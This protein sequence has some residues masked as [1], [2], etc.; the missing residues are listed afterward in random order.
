MQQ[1]PL[2]Q[3]L[4]RALEERS[5]YM[6]ALARL[7]PVFPFA[8]LGYAL[9]PTSVSV[10]DYSV[11]TALGLYPGCLLYAYLGSSMKGLSDG[12]QGRDGG[13]MFGVAFSVLSTV[14]IS[15]KAKQVF[16][17]AVKPKPSKE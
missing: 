10:R 8:I 13:A 9:G 14:L 2:L 5:L 7:S 17:E 11:G 12:G 15:W 4:D 16:D 3:A 6:I 1:Y